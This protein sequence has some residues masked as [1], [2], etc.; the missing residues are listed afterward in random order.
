MEPWKISFLLLSD[1][2]DEGPIITGGFP[3]YHIGDKVDVNCTSLRSVPAAKLKW[4]INGEQ[5]DPVFTRVY[6]VSLVEF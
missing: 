1:L 6:K 5:A 2:P 3:R 4:Y